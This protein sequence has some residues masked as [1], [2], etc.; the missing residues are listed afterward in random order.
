[1]KM[2]KRLFGYK[3]LKS[4]ILNQDIGGFGGAGEYNFMSMI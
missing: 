1:M 3:I 2:I 4:G